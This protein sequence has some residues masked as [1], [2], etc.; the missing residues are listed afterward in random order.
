VRSDAISLIEQFLNA[1]YYAPP[2]MLP[3]DLYCI[4]RAALVGI[5]EWRYING[6]ARFV[7]TVRAKYVFSLFS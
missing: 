5:D 3:G 1:P 6:E 4:D 7:V 2:A